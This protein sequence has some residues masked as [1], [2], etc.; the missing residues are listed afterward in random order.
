MTSE[1]ACCKVGIA[2]EKYDLSTR[3][4]GES[5]NETLIDRWGTTNGA[6]STSIRSLKD[7]LNKQIL[8]AV[9]SQHG[10][11]TIQ[12]RIESD[13]NAIVGDDEDARQLVIDDLESDGIDTAALLD[14]FVSTATMYRHL[15]TCLEVTR[16]E[17]ASDTKWEEEKIEFILSNTRENKADIL[18]SWENKN[19][20]PHASE[21]GISVKLYVECPECGRQTDL[22]Y[23]KDRGVVCEDHL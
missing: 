14:D 6:A 16:E 17:S 8:I 19:V 22:R 11:K 7:W 18:Q 13:Y 12:T 3:V 23:L 9:A 10:R 21:A 20:V 15:T 5:V 4:A 2:I 1:R